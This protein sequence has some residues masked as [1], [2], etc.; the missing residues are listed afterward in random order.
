M[1]TNEFCIMPPRAYYSTERFEGSHK[2][3]VFGGM[4]RRL[5]DED[6]LVIFLRPELHN[7]SD[8]GIHFNK[9]FD[10]CVKKIAQQA[11]QDYYRKDETAFIK[12]YGRSYI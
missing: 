8:K 12:R 5:S 3:H 6:G 10:L 1:S 2:H 11:W 7:M 9:D 4:N